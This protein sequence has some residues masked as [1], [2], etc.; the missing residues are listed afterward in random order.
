MGGNRHGGRNS[1]D[2]GRRARLRLVQIWVPDARRPGFA[3]AC[4]R[5]CRLVAKAD[6]ADGA[7][8]RFRDEM[9][10]DVEGWTP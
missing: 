6:K 5:Q 8:H 1:L 2:Q 7:L 4:R 10:A 9:Q 3:A